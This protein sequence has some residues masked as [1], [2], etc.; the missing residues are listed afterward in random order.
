MNNEDLFDKYLSDTLTATEEQELYDLLKDDEISQQLVE[1][2]LEIFTNVKTA[3]DL[4]KGNTSKE[5]S[6][7][8]KKHQEPIPFIKYI[9]MASS[10]AALLLLGLW[11]SRPVS[12]EDAEISKIGEKANIVHGGKFRPGDSIKTNKP[13]HFEFMDGSK[14]KLFGEVTVHS[15]KL[16]YLKSG[17]ININAVPQENGP[18]VVK[19]DNASAEVVGTSFT[20]RRL[21]KETAL[22]VS[23]GKVKFSHEGV[24]EEFSSGIAVVTHKGQ[25]VSSR[26]GLKHVNLKIY[27]QTLVSDP[28]LKLYTPMENTDPLKVHGL[29]TAPSKLVSGTLV[30]GKNEFTRALKNGILEIE[31]SENFELSMPCSFGVWVNINEFENYPPILTKGDNAWRVQMNVNGKRFHI[32]FGDNKQFI[33]SKKFVEAD[34][35]YFLTFVATKDKVKIYVNGELENEKEIDSHNFKNDS[36]IMIGGNKTVP[37]RNFSGLIGSTFILQRELS[38]SEIS[39]LFERYK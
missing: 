11:I 26:K 34:K 16:I 14:I 28:A 3:N 20:V 22:E 4:L 21:E 38:E 23:E 19:T 17:T 27:S 37:Q 2:S 12:I 31:G 29:Y 1:Y 15:D 30:K 6:E 32:G 33:N 39:D 7:L 18:L 24:S 10:A 25:L 5:R 36:T 8:V 35:W 13:T 9:I